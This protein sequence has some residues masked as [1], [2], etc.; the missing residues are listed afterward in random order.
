LP[1]DLGDFWQSKNHTHLRLCGPANTITACRLYFVYDQER[2]K[3]T[4]IL[5]TDGR[6]FAHTIVS[7]K[8]FQVSLKYRV[9]LNKTK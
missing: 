4:S 5:E 3:G 7:L 6:D 1:K 8:G 9:W 2:N